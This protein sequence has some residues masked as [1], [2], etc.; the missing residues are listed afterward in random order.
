MVLLLIACKDANVDNPT[1]KEILS[2]NR[3]ADIIQLDGLIYSRN[4]DENRESDFVRG[5]KIG[6]I[7]EQTT[8]AWWF[9]DLYASKLPK[10]TEIFS[11]E[12]EY[13]QEDAPM[14][15]LVEIDGELMEYHVLVEG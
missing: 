11:T 13:I 9:R 1:A 7:L 10:G 8:K 12:K 3:D 4:I 6:E 14:V 2:E 15:I 5:D